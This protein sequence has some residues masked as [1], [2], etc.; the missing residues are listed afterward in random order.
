MSRVNKYLTT[1]AL[2]ELLGK[3]E[4]TP[5][6]EPGFADLQSAASPL[7]H[8]ASE[9]EALY[10]P[11]RKTAIRHSPSL[12]GNIAGRISP[13]SLPCPL[14]RV[15]MPDYAAARATMV[16]SQVRTNDVTDVRVQQ[17]M[18]DVPRERFVPTTKRG[19]AYADAAVEVVQG[20]FLLDPR[21]FARLLQLAVVAPTDSVLDV[22]CAT[23]YSTVVLARLAKQVIG[24][25][26]DADLVRMASDMIPAAGATNAS[27]VQGSLSVGHRAKAPYN[28]IFLNG[29]IEEEPE[30]LLAQLAD[31]GR[32]VAIM[33]P[34]AQ[35]MAY[36]FERNKTHVGS[37]AAFDAVVPK[38]AGFGQPTGFVF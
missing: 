7:R 28:V 27:V 18:R 17:A 10:R 22:G 30:S 29:A 32:L 8:V 3:M 31:G 36:M 23:G 15:A 24:L 20:R 21:N 13:A 19:I 9:S 33:Q 35:G 5:G 4:A 16:E 14:K 6:I 2:L 1:A 34:G 38:L 12:S 11:P 26:Q 25:E 37:R